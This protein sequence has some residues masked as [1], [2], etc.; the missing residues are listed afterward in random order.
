M[1][2]SAIPYL[3]DV[4][5]A[6]VPVLSLTDAAKR[7]GVP[8]SRVEQMVRDHDLLAFKRQRVPVVPEVFLEDEGRV[9][10]GLPGLI[11]LMRD[12]GYAEEEVLRWL[13][14]DDETLPGTPVEALH[15][16][17]GKEVTR[18]AQAMAL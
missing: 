18:R 4:L 1:R 7:L 11:T 15:H 9:L 8:L 6:D 5:G 3:D 16:D 13:F 2:V 10:K 14:A 17:R 12:G